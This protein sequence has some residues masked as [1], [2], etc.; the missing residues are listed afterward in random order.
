MISFELTAETGAELD[1]LSLA[2][3][4]HLEV[5]PD[6]AITDLAATYNSLPRKAQRRFVYGNDRDSLIETLATPASPFAADVTGA[7]APAENAATGDV[8]FIF[9]G[10]GAQRVGM[11]QGLYQQ[12]PVFTDAIDRCAE[13]LAEHLGLDI[14]SEMWLGA[15]ATPEQTKAAQARLGETWLTQPTIF[16]IEF[17][18]AQWLMS[19]GVQPTA[20]LGHSIGELTAAT[21]AEIVSLDDMVRL[22]ANRGHAM[23]RAEPGGMIAIE[24][25]MDVVEPLLGDGIELAAHN[26]P[27]SVALGGA[28]AA[29]DRLEQV[30]EQQGLDFRKL[31]ISHAFHTETMSEAA[32]QIA[33]I[34]QSIE[35]HAPKIPLIS[36]VTGEWFGE[37]E[38][39][40][41]K[42]WA[43]QIRRPV[44]FAEGLD[45]LVGDSPRAFVEVGPAATLTALVTTHD[46]RQGIHHSRSTLPPRTG[47]VDDVAFANSTLAWLR[48]VG[49][50]TPIPKTGSV[51]QLPDHLLA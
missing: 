1:A 30:L 14:R 7:A 20:L 48:A 32:A 15:D 40:D 37:A 3:A 28:H 18:L 45:L 46:R 38:L 11:G 4:H 25:D 13:L 24:A 16:A 26:S 10:Q 41:P 42:Y 21:V 50:A 17:A 39:A 5:T 19:E 34:T 51:V 44:R 27:R 47:Q 12:A 31:R 8:V 6:L 22:V 29:L 35:H 49:C 36:N 23:Y 2:V 33:E 9:T 43:K